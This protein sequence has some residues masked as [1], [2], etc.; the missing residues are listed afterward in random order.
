MPLELVTLT[1]DGRVVTDYEPSDGD[2][3]AVWLRG[4]KSYRYTPEIEGNVLRW[5]DNGELWCGCYDLEVR[6]TQADGSKLR[7]YHTSV[8]SVVNETSVVTDD[9]TSDFLAEGAELDAAFFEMAKGDPGTTS[10]EDIT[11]KPE[12]YTKTETDT[13]LNGKANTA[14]VT[15]LA[16]RVTTAEGQIAG[17]QDTLVSGENIKTINGQSLLGGGNITIEGGGDPYAA[18]RAMYIAA[19][20][21]PQSDPDRLRYNAQTRCYEM[22]R[23]T[24]ITEEQMAAIFAHGHI[25]STYS[26]GH[27]RIGDARTLYP[28]SGNAYYVINSN[29]FQYAPSI[30]SVRLCAK[31]IS[32]AAVSTAINNCFQNSMTNLRYILDVIQCHSG[33]FGTGAFGECAALEYVRLKGLKGDIYFK[34]CSK[35][36]YESLRF[37]VDNAAN[38]AAITVTVHATTY[39]YLTGTI[40]P[41]EQVGGTSA[42]WQQIVAE[43]TAKNISFATA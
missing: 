21:R 25:L 5:E 15:A 32:C 22:N 1:S 8:L 37:L 4:S 6:I 33:K 43:A 16:R 29:Y 35:L 2:V 36:N 27:L 19:D 26:S 42:E 34:Q 14:D 38:T 9:D 20:P 24:D 28:I 23:L 11:D 7:A 12:L 13:L 17:K 31:T 41:T 10:W 30:E 39:G 3:V 40:E 18:L